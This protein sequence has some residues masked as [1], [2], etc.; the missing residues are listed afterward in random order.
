MRPFFPVAAAIALI[1]SSLTGLGESCT[2]PVFRF[3]LD[4]WPGDSFRLEVSPSDAARPEVA[5]FL[6]NFGANSPLNLTVSRL[7]AGAA[8]SILRWPHADSPLWEGALDG[9]A[10]DALTGSPAR[11]ELVKRLLAG[12]NVVWILAEAPDRAANDRVANAVEKRLRYLEQV[13]Q[14]PVIDPSDPDSQLGPGPELVVRFSLLRAG[15]EETALR[16]MLAGTDSG[17]ER[18][19]EP[20][21]AA[22]F[23][24]GRVLGAWP[25]AEAGDEEIEQTCLYL[26]GACSCQVKALNPGWD[27]LL[28]VDWEAELQAVGQPL[29]STPPA[30]PVVPETVKFSGSR[31]PAPPPASR[32]SSWWILGAGGLVALASALVWRHVRRIS[33][34]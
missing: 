23:G 32:G 34:P 24:R 28:P 17:L 14:L 26:L 27:L 18:S 30:A 25:A 31:A 20:W 6:R 33:H 29:L 3:A 15:A 12:D 7:P 13:A 1:W 4:R 19:Q 2:V 5:R 8:A 10:I 9:G 22:V 11:Q 16:Q 21:L